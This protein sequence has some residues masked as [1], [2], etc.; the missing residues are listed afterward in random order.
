MPFKFAGCSNKITAKL[1]DLY[2]LTSSPD[3]ISGAQQTCNSL[4]G[5]IAIIKNDMDHNFFL[6]YLKNT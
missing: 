6:F 4:G 2:I 3:T 1:S 5:F